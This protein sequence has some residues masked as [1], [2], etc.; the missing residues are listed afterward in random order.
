MFGSA[1][2]LM[3]NQGRS[4]DES[5]AAEAARNREKRA[6]RDDRPA[7][8]PGS[9]RHGAVIL[10]S[11]GRRTT[12]PD[13]VIAAR[14]AAERGVRVYTVGFGSQD[15]GAASGS[16]MSYYMQLDEPALRAVAKLTGG[17][18]FHAGSEADLSQV[19]RQ[20]ST[21]FALERRETE[22]GALFAGAAVLLLVAAS[23]LSVLWFRR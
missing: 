15:G 3:E 19:Y 7:A 5:A 6:R 8:E 23:V 1:S 10:L 2:E 21:R 18:Y 17:E 22:I 20:L 4:L 9:Y 16:T 12:G 13:P 11:D 14:M